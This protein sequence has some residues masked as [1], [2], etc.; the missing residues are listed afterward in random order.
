MLTASS[1]ITTVALVLVT[2]ISS[3]SVSAA[4]RIVFPED[5]CVLDVKK[6]LGAKGDGT[7]DDTEV[8]QRALDIGSGRDKEAKKEHGN[9]TRVVYLPN[10]TYRLTRSLVVNSSVGPWLYG[11]TRDG[12]VLKLD[13]GVQ[14]VTAVLR[15]HPKEKGPTSADWFMRNLRNFTVDAGNNPSTDGIRYY[16]TNTG[17]L[18]DVRVIGRGKVGINAGF[19]DQSGPNLIQDVEIEGFDRGIQSQWVWGGTLSRVT[20]RNCRHEGLYVNANVLAIEGLR[21]EGTPIGLINDMPKGQ[22]WWGGVVAITD[23]TFTG[24]KADGPAI[25]NNSKLY[26][27]NVQAVGFAKAIESGG[28]N[29]A[30]DGLTVEEF[31]SQKTR[32]LWDDAPDGAL[33]LPIKHEPEVPWETDPTKWL[34]VDD[35]GAKSGDNQDDTDAIES[36]L[37]AAAKE[38][39]TVVYFRGI[40]GGDPNWYTLKRPLKVPSPVRCVLGLGFGRVLGHKAEAGFIVDDASAPVVKFQNLDSFGGPPISLT[41]ASAKNTLLAESCGVSII[42]D[43]AGDIFINDCPAAIHLKKK[44]QHCW[45]RHLNPEGTSD[46]GL[47]QNEGGVLWCLGVKHEGKGVRFATKAGGQTEILGLFNYGGTKDELDPRP[48]FIIEDAAFSLA[49]IREIAFNQHTFLNKVRET[50]SG[51]TRIFDKNTVQEHGWIGWSL[52]SGWK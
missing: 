46:D 28:S 17:I 26:A 4:E 48:C 49:G 52:Y 3:S 37:A 14:D 12:V 29:G 18:K 2:A 32:K 21:V 8:L 6:Y 44:G 50:R 36:A 5:R 27:R 15:T 7:T 45:A 42:G 20:I 35:Y 22:G 31:C 34:C 10:G 38:G 43:G 33:K 19:L 23:A 51:E 41:N 39:K 13:D 11:E 1:F 16:A 30:C 24:G 25:V 40:G 47:V 9:H